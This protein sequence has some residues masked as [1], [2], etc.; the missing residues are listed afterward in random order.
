VSEKIG[1]T[2]PKYDPDR[3]AARAGAALGLAYA[4]HDRGE[5]ISD[6]R[7]QLREARAL[8]ATLKDHEGRTPRERRPRGQRKTWTI[9]P[10]DAL[11]AAILKDRQIILPRRSRSK[12]CA[13][14]GAK[15][16]GR[17]EDGDPA[18]ERCVQLVERAS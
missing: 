9:H 11:C 16:T 6:V 3:M 4:M 2:G 12:K 10:I 15:A 18:C 7:N 17:D 8:V 5:R 13:W 14:C 1:R